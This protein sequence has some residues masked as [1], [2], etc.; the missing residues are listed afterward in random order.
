MESA[1][2]CKQTLLVPSYMKTTENTLVMVITYYL[3]LKWSNCNE[4]LVTIVKLSR[5]FFF[6][7][8]NSWS[9]FQVAQNFHISLVIHLLRFVPVGHFL[10]HSLYFREKMFKIPRKTWF[11]A[12]P[13][14]LQQIVLN[15]GSLFF[16]WS[17]SLSL[18]STE[19]LSFKVSTRELLSS[20]PPLRPPPWSE[21]RTQA[22]FLP[23]IA[24][25]PKMTDSKITEQPS[26]F[27]ANL[28]LSL[29]HN[30]FID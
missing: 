20:P 5:Q 27:Q 6:R 9:W 19:K 24:T 15:R 30:L 11:P 2:C 4:N 14:N 29:P 7:H 10:A 23:D 17:F 16:Q 18:S 22:C 25:Q 21:K 28:S 1:V 12:P 8:Y 26:Y 13:T 3:G